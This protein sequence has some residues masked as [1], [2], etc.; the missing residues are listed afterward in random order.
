M[1]WCLKCH[2][3][4][5]GKHSCNRLADNVYPAINISKGAE[6]HPDSKGIHYLP[7]IGAKRIK[8]RTE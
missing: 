8:E 3:S 2:Y 7:Y 5:N 1:D 4:E 6:C